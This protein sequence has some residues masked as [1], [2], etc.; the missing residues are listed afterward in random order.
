MVGQCDFPQQLHFEELHS[1]IEFFM[2]RQRGVRFY[3]YLHWANGSNSHFLLTNY[4]CLNEVQFFRIILTLM[5]E[6]IFF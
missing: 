1:I 6:K 2:N 4:Q 5:Q 3:G